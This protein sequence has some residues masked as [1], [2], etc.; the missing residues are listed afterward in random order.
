MNR[1]LLYQDLHDIVR[2]EKRWLTMLQRCPASYEA[3]QALPEVRKER[4]RIEREIKDLVI[5]D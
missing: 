3:R 4:I 5:Y 2:A 1:E